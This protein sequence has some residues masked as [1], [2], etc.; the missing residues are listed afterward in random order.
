MDGEPRPSAT[1][2]EDE[3]VISLGAMKPGMRGTIVAFADQAGTGLAA[4]TEER[5][6]EMGFAE[7][8]ELALTHQ[9][10]F[11]KDPIAVRIGGMAVA[12]RRREASI[13]MV[14]LA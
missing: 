14:H 6:R 12:L 9:S 3:S 2:G 13:V 10:P 5:L 7:G 4:G 8:L 1:A 11:G